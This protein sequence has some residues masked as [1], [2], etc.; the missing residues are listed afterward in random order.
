MSIKILSEKEL[1]NALSA[2]DNIIAVDE[3]NKL[4]EAPLN[5][6]YGTLLPTLN[7][8]V[9]ED[10]KGKL[11]YQLTTADMD[12]IDKFKANYLGAFG[13]L[14]ATHVGELARGNEE[15]AALDLTHTAGSTQ[16]S[17]VW[18]RPT[19][20]TP[21]QKDYNSSIGFGMSSPKPKSLE[22]AVRKAFGASFFETEDDE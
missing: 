13:T 11:E 4:V 9:P 2:V 20:E 8:T 22:G 15:I 5:D 7:L 12:G 14:A 10:H 18:S 17:T 19:N 6:L 3:N 16:Y 21:T 1:I